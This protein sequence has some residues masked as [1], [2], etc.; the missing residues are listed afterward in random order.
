MQNPV[1]G[2][3]TTR[4]LT[5]MQEEARR[6][7]AGTLSS[8]ARAA[9]KA[10]DPEPD[11]NSAP[12]S[13]PASKRQQKD[14]SGAQ[15]TGTGR[16]AS[17]RLDRKASPVLVV[18]MGESEARMRRP[19]CAGASEYRLA[20]SYWMLVFPIHLTTQGAL[21]ALCAPVPEEDNSYPK[22]LHRMQ[23]RAWRSDCH[24]LTDLGSLHIGSTT[25][26][27]LAA[28]RESL[29]CRSKSYTYIPE[30][31]LWVE[32]DRADSWKKHWNPKRSRDENLDGLRQ[33]EATCN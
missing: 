8:A 23:A 11:A 26:L 25:H 7:M 15:R 18:N 21:D 19:S 6:A 33:A 14:P 9:L 2:R 32:E 20:C 22:R 10:T 4:Q 5:K 28:I 27:P 16:T 3:P 17:S 1:V 24:I 31:D 12:V 30:V 29:P 13:G